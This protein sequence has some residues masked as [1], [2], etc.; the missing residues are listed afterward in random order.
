MK[1][2]LNEIAI[3]DLVAD[4]K[5]R[6]EDGVVGY[7]GK[8]DIRPK[9]QREFVYNDKQR[10]AVIDTVR[11]NFPLNVMYWV[12]N[13]NDTFEILDGQQRTVSICEYIKGAFSVNFQYFHNLT[14][15]EQEQIFDYKILVYFCKGNARE[16]LDWFRTI[17][18]AGEKLTE[19]EIR[20]VVYTGTWLTDAKKYFSK[21]NCPAWN[22]GKRFLKGSPIRQD[23]LETVLKWVSNNN[24]EDY[25][26]IHQHDTDASELWQYFQ[27]VIN[28]FTTLFPSYREEMKGLDFG[29]L[30]TCY[31]DDMYNSRNLEEQVKTLMQD[32]DVTK[33]SGIYAYLLSGDEKH[34]SIRTFTPTQKREVFE[35]QSGICPSCGKTFEITEMEADHIVAWSKGGRTTTD[36]CQVLCKKCNKEKSD[37]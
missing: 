19:Q 37:K 13:E 4:Y 26:A 10:K 14:E 36:N 27:S 25:M 15:E 2:E 12:D 1:I 18:I 5:N 31:K 35:R 3:R 6:D 32:D 21:T 30:H 22:V 7:F 8:L 11:S 28:W 34:L 24:V 29:G 16:K 20:N 23:F 9:Y 17:N 33:K